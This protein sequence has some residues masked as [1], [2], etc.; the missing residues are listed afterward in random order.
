MIQKLL[1]FKRPTYLILILS[2]VFFAFVLN[3]TMK[4]FIG[5]FL[6]ISAMLGGL[7]LKRTGF[8][9]LILTLILQFVFFAWFNALP[10]RA[11]MIQGTIFYLSLAL[12]I[13][14]SIEIKRHIEELNLRKQENC[15]LT[16]E[17]IMS[18]I[19]AIDAKDHY[20]H[21][22]SHNV[23]QYALKLGNTM[24][25]SDS[26]LKALGLAAI[27]HDIG[28]LKISEEILNK[29]AKL[30]LEEWA[31]MKSHP[32]NGTEIL[33]NVEQFRKILPDIKYHH[34][35][36]DGSGY[37]EDSP[38]HEVPL[39]A[40]I[41]MVADSFDAMTSDRPY[42]KALTEESAYEELR[43]C[44]GTQFNP[45]VVDAFFKAGIC[46]IPYTEE[47]PELPDLCS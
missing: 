31:I 34:R 21:N 38:S 40:H 13:G 7:T 20:L 28:K 33:K 25:F 44:S 26:E 3:I 15:K 42:R 24:G 29:P 32:A 11:V 37:P 43:R 4:M 47:R 16:N 45:K 30:S 35:Y 36:Y 9:F 19:E 46:T 17:L 23:C 14:L 41:I 39:S 18:F 8:I 12:T 22:H 6:L 10:I 5:G 2:I 1:A 27:F